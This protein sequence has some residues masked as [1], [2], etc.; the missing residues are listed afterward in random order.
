MSVTVEG[1]SLDEL[2]SYAADPDEIEVVDLSG[3][4]VE[5]IVTEALEAAECTRA[6]LEQQAADGEFTSE[7]ARRMWF[8]VS[9]LDPN[10]P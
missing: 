10:A 3:E 6:E 4:D 5:R 8:L 7:V 9:S 2:P 1:R